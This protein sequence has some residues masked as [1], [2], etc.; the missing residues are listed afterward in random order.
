VNLFSLLGINAAL[1]RTFTAEE[2]EA[3]HG[4]VVVL[5][6]GLWQRRFGADPGLIGKT[7]NLDGQGYTIIGVMPPNFQFFIK[8]WS[9]SGKPA[10][11]WVPN[12]FFTAQARIRRGRAWQAVAR[13]KPGTSVEQAQSEMNTIAGRLEQQYSDFN[14]GW[15]ASVVP[16]HEQFTGEI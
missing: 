16:L 2:G 8:Q 11:L 7:I 9:L 4:N 6:Y 13:L 1:G 3:G 14:K 10:E 12:T 15:G 5:S